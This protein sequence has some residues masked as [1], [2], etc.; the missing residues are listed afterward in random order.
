MAIPMTIGTP[1][2]GRDAIRLLAVVLSSAL[3][4]CLTAASAF[5]AEY[6]VN[7]TQDL[8]PDGSCDATD[9]TLREALLIAGA[10][11][12]SDTIVV[13]PGSYVLSASLG[14][15]SLT[16]DTIAGAGAR[17]TVINGNGVR[18]L[19][20]TGTSAI[21]GVT[22]TGGQDQQGA[23][24]GLVV[25]GSL[26]M[27]NS[28]VTGN[29][30][31]A[32]GG[33]YVPGTLTM[34]GSTVA[35][36]RAAALSGSQGGGIAIG[37]EGRAFLVNSTVAG[38]VA[39]DPGG[40]SGQGGGIYVGNTAVL[41]LT[42]T[43]VA[44]NDAAANAGGGLFLVN[45]GGTQ[46]VNTIIDENGG[47]ACAGAIGTIAAASHHNLVQDGT[48]ALQGAGNLQG[49]SAQ[50]LGLGSHGGP[51]DTRAL[52]ATSSARNTGSDCG[53]A[54][55]RGVARPQG[56]ACDIGA[57]EYVAPTLTVTTAVTN[58]DGGEDG[59]SDFDVHVRD[60]AGAEVAGSPQPGAATG[61]TY[62][63]AAGAFKVSAAG[64]RL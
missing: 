9:C 36:N 22:I 16:G 24:G 48:C 42:S 44:G 5:A 52:V 21:A 45:F 35:G 60:A 25:S 23:G 6:P 32:G 18:V 31:I 62:T 20:T 10:A 37:G 51:T 61:T 38:N 8:D 15:L 17:T 41:G 58:N 46:L 55:Q 13:P 63:L 1:V 19:S 7:T 53:T 28:H 29:T 49:A 4:V 2:H 34:I 40:T 27:T 14:T 43:T 54:D 33:L 50:L 30:A 47:G 64:P 3:A 11:G 57:F 26:Q 56:G 39:L 59:P 12:G